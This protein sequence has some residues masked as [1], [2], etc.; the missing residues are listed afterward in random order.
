MNNIVNVMFVDVVTSTTVFVGDGQ[1]SL[2]A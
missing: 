1:A 2:D